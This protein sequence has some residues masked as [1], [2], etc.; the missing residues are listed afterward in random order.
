MQVMYRTLER[1]SG[2]Y[3]KTAV[4]KLALHPGARGRSCGQ[5]TFCDS[6][7]YTCDMLVS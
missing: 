6:E 4:F 2:P 3:V 1:E 7:A 5:S